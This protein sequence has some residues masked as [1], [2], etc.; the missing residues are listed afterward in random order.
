M[1]E[2]VQRQR[3]LIIDDDMTN[4]K[5]LGAALQSDYAILFSLDAQGGLISATANK[6]DLILL[7]VVMPGMDGYEACRRLKADELTSDIPVIFITSRTDEE[8]EAKGFEA[9]GVD[10][11][12]KPFSPVITKARVKTHLELKKRTDFLEWM[13]REKLNALQEMEKEYMKLFIKK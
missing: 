7:D 12:N 9:G 6:P 5:I 2:E 13:L 4:I 11:I 10:Y 3:I 8:D 1:P